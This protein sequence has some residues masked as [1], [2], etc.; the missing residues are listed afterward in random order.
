MAISSNSHDLFQADTQLETIVLI[1]GQL[2]FSPNF[3]SQEKADNLFSSLLQEIEWKQETI[4]IAGIAR[5][6]PR[7]SAWYG[8]AHAAYSYSGIHLTPLPWTVNLLQIKHAI[9]IASDTAFN[10]VL[11][12]LYRNEQDSMGWHADN[13]IELEKKPCIASLS[14]GETRQFLLK[15]NNQQAKQSQKRCQI[16]LT[17]GSLLLME[18][19]TQSHWLHSIPKEKSVC[20]ARINLTFRNIIPPT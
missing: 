6:Q 3:F 12:N 14:L 19:D 5:Q 7:L 13:E 17:H 1:N 2:R 20:K 9:E 8:D 16:N 11:L 18:A 4:R 15:P 10:S